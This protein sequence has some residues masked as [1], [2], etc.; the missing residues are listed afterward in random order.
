[1]EEDLIQQSL[2]DANI[3]WYSPWLLTVSRLLD[4]HLLEP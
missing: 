1:M 4:T 2:A 3:G